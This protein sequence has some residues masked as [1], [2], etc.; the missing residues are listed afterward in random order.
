M[1]VSG[2]NLQLHDAPLV[3]SSSLFPAYS[4]CYVDPLATLVD[5]PSENDTTNFR[6]EAE[7]AELLGHVLEFVCES[8]KLGTIDC[9][10]AM[11]LDRRLKVLLLPRQDRPDDS[12]YSQFCGGLATC[13]W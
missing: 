12:L 10:K 8:H 13:L 7:A 6:L 9:Q 3:N 1:T 11:Q 4:A 2:G 5:L